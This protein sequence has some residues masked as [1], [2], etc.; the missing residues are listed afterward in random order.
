MLGGQPPGNSEMSGNSEMHH[1]AAKDE[2]NSGYPWL[3]GLGAVFSL[4]SGWIS[5]VSVDGGRRDLCALGNN[6][7]G[8]L[9]GIDSSRF[10][11]GDFLDLVIVTK[12]VDRWKLVSEHARRNCVSQA[13]V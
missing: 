12:F 7:N 13:L 1:P 5:K 4:L 11:T 2:D 3:G 10:A 9:V 8:A 6:I